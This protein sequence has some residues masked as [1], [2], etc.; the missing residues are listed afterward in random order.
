MICLYYSMLNVI[1][2]A[3]LNKNVLESLKNEGQGRVKTQSGGCVPPRYG[4]RRRPRSFCVSSAFILLNLLPLLYQPL[5]RGPLSSVSGRAEP[6]LVKSQ[7]RFTGFESNG[8][9]F[10]CPSNRNGISVSVL[11]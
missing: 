2:K 7:L 10:C 4:H 3:V 1:N 11:F 9:D 8:G 5:Q 6:S